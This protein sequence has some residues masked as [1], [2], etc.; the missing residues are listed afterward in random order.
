M[1]AAERVLATR[2]DLRATV[3]FF[4]GMVESEWSRSSIAMHCDRV[5]AAEADLRSEGR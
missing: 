3:E 4:S 1:N 5:A 2:D